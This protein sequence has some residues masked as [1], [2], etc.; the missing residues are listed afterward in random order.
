M[1]FILMTILD[2]LLSLLY[3]FII[4]VSDKFDRTS[5][6][7]F[8]SQMIVRKTW[9]VLDYHALTTTLIFSSVKCAVNF[10]QD[11]S[12]FECL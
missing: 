8:L 6:R 1:D 10:I 2:D 9:S 4:L 11:L 5:W 3:V 12:N 7:R